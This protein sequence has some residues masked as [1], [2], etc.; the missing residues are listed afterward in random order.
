MATSSSLTGLRQLGKY[1]ISEVLGKG[2]LGPVYKGF[3]PHA[4][5]TVALKTVRRKRREIGRA[6]CRERV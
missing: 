6:S 4:R 5:R 2:A 3:D 1:T